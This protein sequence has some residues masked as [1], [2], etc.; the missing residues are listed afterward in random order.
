[1]RLELSDEE[2]DAVDCVYIWVDAHVVVSSSRALMVVSFVELSLQCAVC[3]VVC[4]CAGCSG[5]AVCFIIHC[6]SSLTRLHDS[7]LTF[8]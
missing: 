3:C 5:G 7:L 4:G 1:M 8:K 6:A 2:V